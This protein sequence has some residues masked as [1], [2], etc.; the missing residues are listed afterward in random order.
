[1][2]LI[3]ESLK[4]QYVAISWATGVWRRIFDACV[5]SW[6]CEGDIHV[7]FCEFNFQRSLVPSCL[8]FAS[9]WW[10]VCWCTWPVSASCILITRSKQA[11]WSLFP[12]VRW[13]PTLCKSYHADCLPSLHSYLEKDLEVNPLRLEDAHVLTRSSSATRTENNVGH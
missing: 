12:A 4:K 11:S 8:S 5:G 7:A 13:Q 3:H 2:L 9:G 1:M 6:G 10:L